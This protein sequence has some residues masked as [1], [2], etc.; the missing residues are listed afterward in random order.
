MKQIKKVLFILF[1]I[2]SS[3]LN[4]S[5]WD[6]KDVERLNVVMSFAVDKDVKT[7]EYIL[8]VEV[9]R[10]ESGQNQAKYMSDIYES[11]GSTLFYA[12]R[13]LIPRI[14]KKAFWSHVEI[15][16]LGKGVVS[17]DITPAI[18]FFYRDPEARGDMFI[19]VSKK[20]T[21]KEILETAHNP[22]E[23][24]ATKL[25]YVM[26]NQ[27]NSPRFPKTQ[28]KDLIE[29]FESKDNA[30][31]I[32]LVDIKEANDSMTTEISGSAILKYDRVVG[33][34]NPEETQYALWAMNKLDGGLLVV[35]NVGESNNNITFEVFKNATKVK[36]YYSNEN[37]KIKLSASTTVNIGEE[38][39]DVQFQKKEEKE[40]I[41]NQSEKI[42]EDRLKYVIKKMQTEYKSDVFSFGQKVEIQ[43]TKLWKELK[44]K[45]SEEFSS[46]PV[47]VDVELLIQ[48]SAMT[49]QPTKGEK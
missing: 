30:I 19:L 13:N 34:L 35:Q 29:N 9:A 49:T 45:W 3:F 10:P 40:K 14:G 42:L 47:E 46:L 43:N 33:Y 22:Q 12:V 1:I 23:L 44:P 27:K 16:I 26:E 8:T 48:G 36:T 41:K 37:L 38:S 24:R 15:G 4:T 5:C 31:L 25:R 39:G 18:D 2:S 17:E 32:P 7:K 6:Y 11:R 21:A 28:L 20:E